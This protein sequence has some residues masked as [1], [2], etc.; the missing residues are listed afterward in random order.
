MLGLVS[1]LLYIFLFYKIYKGW[2]RLKERP[3]HEVMLFMLIG[4]TFV[5]GIGV[6]NIGTAIRHKTKFIILILLMAASS[7]SS[8]RKISNK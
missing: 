2:S 6:T 4:L 7:F 1:A 8:K 5:F 3:E